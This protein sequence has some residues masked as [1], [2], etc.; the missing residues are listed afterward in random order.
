MALLQDLSTGISGA[1]RLMR[2]DPRGMLL[3][4]R[5][6][7]ECR[8]SF[9]A[10]VILFP[11]FMLIMAMNREPEVWEAVGPA[12][13][14][15]VETIGYVVRWTVFPLAS[16]PLCVWLGRGQLYPGFITAY[17]WAQVLETVPLALLVAL[18]AMGFISKD[19]LSVLFLVVLSL[20]YEGFIAWAALRIPRLAVFA[21]VLLDITAAE[22]VNR[23]TGSFY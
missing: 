21:M 20:I 14:L 15:A 3:F 2:A 4:T 16:L 6:V 18:S 19:A 8:R 1:W 11:I 7:E 5:T 22:F 17:N 13:I 12:R 23:L 10:G 9:M